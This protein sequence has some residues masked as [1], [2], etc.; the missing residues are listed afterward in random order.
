MNKKETLNEAEGLKEL[1]VDLDDSEVKAWNQFRQDKNLSFTIQPGQLHVHDKNWQL[2]STIRG[3]DPH[4]M[5]SESLAELRNLF[6][7]T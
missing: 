2:I 7:Q 1:G 3:S 5:I 6:A 4:T